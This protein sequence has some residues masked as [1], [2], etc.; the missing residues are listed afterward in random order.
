[1]ATNID[2]RRFLRNSA[3]GGAVML[4]GPAF[5]AACGDDD[6]DTSSSS[7]G[8]SSS[9]FGTL[10]VQLNWLKNAEY[11][12]TWIADDSGFFTDAGF[13]KINF[14]AGGPGVSQEQSVISGKGLIGLTAP[15][16]TASAVKEGAKLVILSALFQ[17]NPFCFMSLASNPIKTPEELIG[18]KVGV[19]DVN[20]P[21]WQAFLKANGLDE[22]KMTVVPVQFD[23]QGL[24][25]GE[26]DAW[27][28]FVTNE[29]NALKAEGVDVEVF[30][31]ADHGYPMVSQC[32][33]TTRDTLKAKPDLL[34]AYLT[35]DVKGWRESIKDPAK[36]AKLAAEKYGKDL[37]LKVEAAT[38]V[39]GSP[40]RH[41]RNPADRA[42]FASSTL[43]RWSA[44][45]RT[46][47]RRS[48]L[49]RRVADSRPAPGTMDVAAPTVDRYGHE[50]L[51]GI[52]RPGRGLVRHRQSDHR[53]HAALR[54]DAAGAEFL[55]R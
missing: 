32:Y 40:R 4:G 23:P 35:A 16:F 8:S 19:Q 25:T 38:E 13:D 22:S 52:A 28:S 5:L 3:F 37:G 2:R 44:A 41:P 31:L 46:G 9:K 21:T 12:G 55:Q 54:G 14:I 50:V 15:D 17:K 11:A 10:D 43:Q 30:L 1:M 39:R 47:P 45:L 36:G 29:P 27:F 6:K 42:R 33:F 48:D 18:K 34:Q 26:V 20:Q 49:R 7:S 53:A 24:V 51:G